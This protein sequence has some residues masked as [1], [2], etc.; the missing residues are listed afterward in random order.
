MAERGLHIAVD[1]D[2]VVVDFWQG[3]VNSFNLEFG[4]ELVWNGPWDDVML[5]EH[6]GL[7]AAG[8]KSWW[9]WMRDRE[10]L[11][12]QF[13]AVPGAIAGV[14]SLRASGCWVEALTSKPEWA[15]H[16]VWKWLG[17]WRP[18]FNQVTIVGNGTRKVDASAARILVDDKPANCKEFV[19]DNRHAILFDRMYRSTS[20]GRLK[21]AG[22][23]HEVLDIVAK[24][25]EDVF[26]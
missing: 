20:D 13:S 7:R 18:H 2:D 8:Y 23:W 14:A 10:W 11:W 24:L 16:N 17:K 1:L 22:D 4:Y 25:R 15:E 21:V 9:D 3:V 12:A 26:V 6:P 5:K 19:F